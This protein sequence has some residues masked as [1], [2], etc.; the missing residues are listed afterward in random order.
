MCV[1]LILVGCGVGCCSGFRC[2]CLGLLWVLWC[3]FLGVDCVGVGVVG[4]L[5]VCLGCWEFWLFCC[6]CC[7]SVVGFVGNWFVWRIVV[8]CGYGSVG[9]SC[10]LNWWSWLVYVIVWSVYWYWL[11]VVCRFGDFI[12]V[13]CGIVVLVFC[14][15]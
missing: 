6:I 3:C 15:G 10:V 7:V 11:F 9:F 1:F 5:V 4:V 12:L 8:F 13:F 2:W 14:V